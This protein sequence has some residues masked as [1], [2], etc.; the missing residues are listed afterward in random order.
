M[1]ATCFVHPMDVL[2]N[3]MQMSKEGVTISQTIS[4]IFRNEGIFKFYAGLSAGLVR[5]ATYTTARLGI[6]NQLQDT[7]R[8]VMV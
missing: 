5:Q 7:Y 8:S 4:T 6:Y 3:R 1:C 2:K